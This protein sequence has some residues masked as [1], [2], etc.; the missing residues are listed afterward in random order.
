[1]VELAPLATVVVNVIV[2][3]PVDQLI[4]EVIA[5]GVPNEYPITSKSEVIP[6]LLIV[7]VD[8]DIVP[9][10]LIGL[11]W[12]LV[13]AAA[14]EVAPVPPFASGIVSVLAK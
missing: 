5:E 11:V 9:V 4:A 14:A 2:P 8:P 10:T 1:M 3:L 13:L 6:V 12:R 7:V